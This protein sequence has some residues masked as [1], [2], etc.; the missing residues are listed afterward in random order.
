M[1][2]RLYFTVDADRDA[3][4]PIP[5]SA[6]AGSADRGSGTAPRFS[7]SERGMAVLAELLDDMGV[8]GTFFMEG[9]TAEVTE[10]SVLAGHCI[11]LHGYGHE[12]LLG[13]ETGVVPDV[14]EVL[15]RGYDAVSDA[16]SPPTCFRAPYMAAD[17]RVLEAVR[18]LG[19]GADSS[20]YTPVGGPAEPYTT[21][22]MTEYP[23]P[24]ARDARG[25]VIAAY[26]W[27][28]HEGRRAPSDYIAMAEGL[29]HLVLATHTW[30]MVETREGGVMDGDWVSANADRVRQVLE[31]IL[32]LGFEPCVIGRRSEHGRHIQREVDYPILHLYVLET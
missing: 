15:R 14:C 17:H 19:I 1:T 23:V 22:G 4:I 6:A 29:S 26:L 21:D 20:F 13:K 8:R 16:L 10:C 11:G 32:D 2:R 12:D 31:G 3:N 25:K 5:G 18:G 24:K 27:P 28:M 9:R 30:H 7:S